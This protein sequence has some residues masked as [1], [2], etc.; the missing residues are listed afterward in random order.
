MEERG[1]GEPLVVERALRS[2]WMTRHHLGLL[3]GRSQESGSVASLLVLLGDERAEVR[4]AAAWALSRRALDDSRALALSG[5]VL[6][7]DGDVAR[8]AIRSL[9]RAGRA[10][11]IGA[12]VLLAGAESRRRLAEA[13][14]GVDV[15]R[16]AELDL[17]LAVWRASSDEEIATRRAAAAALTRHVGDGSELIDVAREML[18]SPDQWVRGWGAT[19]LGRSGAAADLSLL[20][21]VVDDESSF[22][23]VRSIEASIRLAGLYGGTLDSSKL[24][25]FLDDPSARV[26]GAAIDAL[27]GLVH[28][29]SVR[30]SLFDMWESH[31]AR[32]A[33]ARAR[34]LRA[35]AREPQDERLHDAVVSAA[36]DAAPEVRV[37]GLETAFELGLPRVVERLAGDRSPRVRAAWLRLRLGELVAGQSVVVSEGGLGARG[38]GTG[39]LSTWLERVRDDSSAELRRFAYLLLVGAPWATLEELLGLAPTATVPAKWPIVERD[40]AARSCLLLALGA[41]GLSER[42]ERGAVMGLLESAAGTDPSM[43]VRLAARDMLLALGQRLRLAPGRANLTEQRALALQ[44]WGPGSENRPHLVME[45]ALGNV[46]WSLDFE[47]APRHALSMLHLAQQGY[48]DGLQLEVDDQRDSVVFGDPTGLGTGDAG[49]RTLSEPGPGGLFVPGVLIGLPSLPIGGGLGGS[50]F[51]I[52]L[53]PQPW[54]AGG[55]TVVGSVVSGMDV[56]DRLSTGARIERIRVSTDR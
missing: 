13:L 31:E 28:V 55:E 45:T 46:V 2:D 19:L 29:K 18:S 52:T 32:L 47:A 14:P 5:A 44:A 40:A 43:E 6:D 1:R 23:R 41:R 9:L 49:Y 51:R 7:P 42:L 36:L 38:V 33:S 39:G 12:P 15:D 37:A 56:L 8:Q 50:Q 4:E 17:A 11:L 16:E 10:D 25:D 21:S 20:L 53:S 34:L 26:R 22:V 35:L 48:Y 30:D 27:G 54:L 24:V 3:L